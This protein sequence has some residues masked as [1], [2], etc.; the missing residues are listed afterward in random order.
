MKRVVIIGG[1]FAGSITAKRLEKDFDVILIDTKDYF[2]FTPGILRTIVSPSKTEKIQVFHRV[3]LRKAMFMKGTVDSIDRKTVF[4]GNKKLPYDYLVICSGSGYNLPIKEEKVVLADRLKHIEEKQEEFVRAK[5]VLII[6]GGLVGVELAGEI[7]TK[8]EKGI[9]IVHAMD[10]LLERNSKKVSA[11]AQRFLE[12]RGVKLIFNEFFNGRGKDD[13]VT[14]KKTRLKADLLFACTGIHPN[15]EFMIRNFSRTINKKGQIVVDKFL[16][17]KGSRNIFAAGDVND[18]L[19]EKTAQNA[20]SQAK[21]AVNNIRALEKKKKLRAY[22]SKVT[23]LAISL[24][25]WNGI[26]V[27]KNLFIT[28]L[29]PGLIKQLIELFYMLKYKI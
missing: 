28:G 18:T 26:F 29:L 22:K 12:K 2:E 7:C 9:T 27:W 1:G 6:G 4:I 23:P 8:Y 19:V 10:R 5:R 3:Y 16:N 11:Y 17:V 24:G 25:K 13:Y 20:V 21:T 15:S 14:D